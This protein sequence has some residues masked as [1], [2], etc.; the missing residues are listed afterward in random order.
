[1]TYMKKIRLTVF[2]FIIIIFT[3]KVYSHEEFEEWKS[4]F[5]KYALKQGISL[6]T[7]NLIIDKTTFLP[8]VIKYD[9]YQPEFYEDTKTYILKRTSSKKIKIGE[10]IYN[11]NQRTINLISEMYKVDKNLLLSLMGIETN[12]GNYLGKMDIIS[13]L[14]TLSFD[15]RRSEFFTSE[16]ITLLKL[17]DAKIVDPETLYGSWAG[18]FG[19]F[20]FM[21]STIKNHAIDFNK[22]GKIELKKTEDSFASAANYLNNL[23]WSNN[24]P[25]FYRIVLKENI[26]D[27]YLN[28]S[29]KKIHNIKKVSYLKKYIKDHDFLNKCH[30]LNAAIITPDAEIVDNPDKLSPAYIVFDNYRLILKWNRSLRF[31]LA[32]CTLKEKFSNEL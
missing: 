27:L 8:N 26:P 23:G 1:M 15:K 6:N 4:N 9:R 20:Q 2:V 19:N 13:S 14:A 28:F 16:L 10:K 32:I 21:P 24:E 31:A 12:F 29:A 22:N 25:C 11:N 3:S 18:A 30:N 7:L 5:K 17:I